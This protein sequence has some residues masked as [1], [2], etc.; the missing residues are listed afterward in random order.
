TLIPRQS[1]VLKDFVKATFGRES[2][3]G[4]VR[5]AASNVDAKIAARARIYNIGS[6]A[7][8]F[9][10]IVHGMPVSKLSRE[11]YLPGLSAAGGNR[12]NVGIANPANAEAAVFLSLFDESGEFH[13]GV[14]ITVP[15]RSVR[16][17]N[18]IF[19]HFDDAPLD[20]G[21]IQIT[22]DHGVYAYASIVRND[23]GD[24]DFVTAT[25]AQIDTEGEVVAPSC[26]N[27]APIKLAVDPADGWI[28]IF[29]AGT[30]ANVLAPELA[31]RYGFTPIHIY[32]AA[33]PG[34]FA[35]LPQATIAQLRCETAVQLV[36][37]NARG[38]L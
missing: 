26:A 23:T 37:Q 24:A 1:L 9:G 17:L 18:N 7:G 27:P 30:N 25:A 5:V 10:Q 29:H 3:T 34:F 2:A 31:A 16:Q 36:E 28:V 8:Q 20:R 6:S 32:N 12:V 21:T 15:A 33:F 22:S 11:A 38:N 35:E 19:E 14:G 13:G 4:I